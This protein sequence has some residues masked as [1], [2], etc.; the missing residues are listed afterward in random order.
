MQLFCGFAVLA[1]FCGLPVGLQLSRG[2][3]ALMSFCGS[4]VGE[5]PTWA[6]APTWSHPILRTRLFSQA[7]SPLVVPDINSSCSFWERWAH[8]SHL[9]R[10]NLILQH[11]GQRPRRDC[12]PFVLKAQSWADITYMCITMLGFQNLS[13]RQ[14]LQRKTRTGMRVLTKVCLHQESLNPTENE[15]FFLFKLPNKQC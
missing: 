6:G 1:W 11:Q 8:L 7:W 4:H 14:G 5:F 9:Q 10:V 15:S 3:T 2:F 12:G 13:D